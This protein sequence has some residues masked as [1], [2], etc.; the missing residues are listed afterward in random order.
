M[1][2]I[3]RQARILDKRAKAEEIREPFE[4]ENEQ[5]RKNR[6]KMYRKTY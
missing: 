1:K 3:K 2:Q 4:W 6:E 5:E